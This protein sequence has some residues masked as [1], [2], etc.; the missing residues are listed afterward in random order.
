MTIEKMTLVDIDY[1][2]NLVKQY[3]EWTKADE[4]L[5]LAKYQ[6]Y[7]DGFCKDHDLDPIRVV[8]N[9]R[10]KGALARFISYTDG[11][12]PYIDMNKTQAVM[13]Y[14]FNK[15]TMSNHLLHELT[16]YQVY[17]AG[18]GFHDGQADFERQLLINGAS[19]SGY[20]NKHKIV[21]NVPMIAYKVMDEYIAVDKDSNIR[22]RW[23]HKHSKNASYKGNYTCEGVSV[24]I[25]RVGFKIILSK[26][27]LK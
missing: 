11:H 9:G 5:S 13:D 10:L 20:T 15:D 14:K 26:S 25:A 3:T 12:Y 21:S 8:F 1:K 18:K 6:R 27:D 17:K 16:H 23:L 24:V 4:A 19:A 7:A 2:P 22:D